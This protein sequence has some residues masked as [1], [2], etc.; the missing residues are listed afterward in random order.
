V[1]VSQANG[2]IDWNAAAASGLSFAYAAVSDGTTAD[3]MF[4]QNYS[5]IRAASLARG[6]YQLFRPG[7]DPAAQAALMLQGLGTSGPGDLP[8]ALDVEVTDGRPPAALAAEFQTWVA[9][10]Q[11]A[12]GRVPVIFTGGAFWN[13][14]VGSPSFAADPLWIASWGAS[15][16]NLPPAWHNWAFWQY[17]DTAAVPGIATPVDRDEFNGSPADLA[18]LSR[19]APAFSALVSPGIVYGKATT[20]LSGRLAAGALSP[21]ANESVS[22]TLN[23]VTRTTALDGSG[24]FTCDFATGALGVVGS[25]Y[26]VSYSYGGD[27]SFNDTTATSNLTVTRATLTVTANNQTKIT[28]EANPPL[29]V[30]YSG[31]VNGQTLATSGVTGSPDLTTAATAESSPGLYAITAGPGTLAAANYQFTFAGGTLTVLSYAQAAENLVAQVN[32]ASLPGGTRNALDSILQAAI[33]SFDWGDTTPGDN[34]LRAFADH[35]RA[36]SGHQIDVALADSLIA[37][38]RRI[39]NAIG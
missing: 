30:S 8:P 6:A 37:D 33:D 16:P 39:S 26:T 25:P 35:V 22:V 32:A 1:D 17:S 21:P 5:A 7:Q 4:D 19:A 29:T 20:V 13:V 10:V 12:T 34:Q 23:G 2:P 3:A 11:N 27:G 14:D 18:T 15:C 28:G 38:A 24:N 31:F 9:I 36:Q